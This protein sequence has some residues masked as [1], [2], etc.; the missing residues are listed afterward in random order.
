MHIE[1]GL[2][3]ENNLQILLIKLSKSQKKKIIAL[4]GKM[5]H[6]TVVISVPKES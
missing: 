6:G 4:S 5:P 1:H 3:L 2:P